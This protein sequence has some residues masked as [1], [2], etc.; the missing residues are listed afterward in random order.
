MNPEV[1]QL[2]R[3]AIHRLL[4]AVEQIRNIA[5]DMPMQTLHI[6]LLVA[7]N[8]G[9]TIAELIKKTGL[10]QSSCSRNVALLSKVH[11]LGK[12]G[13]GLAEA[14]ED[15]RERRRKVV[16]LTSKGTEAVALIADAVR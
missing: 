7:A 2:D 8:P 13:L 5:S 4:S 14:K 15:P 11:R 1:A 10:S 6:L 9:I 3:I 16:R 12:P